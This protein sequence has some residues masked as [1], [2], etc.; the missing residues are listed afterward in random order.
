[1][2][3]RS[4][5]LLR[6]GG[7]QAGLSL[8]FSGYSTVLGADPECDVCLPDRLILPRHAEF[9]S[10]LDRWVVVS[11]DPRAAIFVNGQPVTG[12]ERINHGDLVTLGTM[13]F[14]AL[15]GAL[16]RTVG[17]PRPPASPVQG[18][19]EWWWDYSLSRGD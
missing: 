18:R 11:L 2:M 6:I 19:E 10:V 16:E 13:T 3:A 7:S 5:T 4:L 15:I 8:V 1:M 17:A 9:R 14:K 12:R